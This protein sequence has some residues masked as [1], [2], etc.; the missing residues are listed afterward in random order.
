MHDD[1][2]AAVFE[3][4]ASRF[5]AERIYKSEYTQPAPHSMFPVRDHHGDVVSSHEISNVLRN[6]PTVDVGFILADPELVSGASKWLDGNKASS[7][8]ATEGG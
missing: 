8:S 3:A 6:V 7:L 2:L 1:P 4:A 5:G